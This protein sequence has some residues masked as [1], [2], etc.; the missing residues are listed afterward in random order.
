RNA[1][2]DFRQT[3]EPAPCYDHSGLTESISLAD[4]RRLFVESLAG[5]SPRT[6]ATYET[7]L[8]RFHEYLGDAGGEPVA[9][10]PSDLPESS[11]HDFHTW[12]V[13]NYGRDDRSTIATYV[14]GVRAFLRFLSRRRLLGPDVSFEALSD[15]ARDAM[16]RGSY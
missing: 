10:G 9:L 15:Q 1:R 12:L 14:A 11:L 16:G 13:R 8:R 2:A 3:T 7:A 6:R 5:K 4:A